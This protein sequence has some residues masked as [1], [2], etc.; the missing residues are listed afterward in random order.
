M[1]K[2]EQVARALCKE[3]GLD[4]DCVHWNDGLGLYPDDAVMSNGK[5]GHY[6]WRR[7]VREARAAIETMRIPTEAMVVALHK[8]LDEQATP[9]EICRVL[10]DAA[11]E[12]Q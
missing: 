8:A 9:N 7:R 3:R 1:T 10:V 5:T 12:E 2:I 6:G 4:P 11:L